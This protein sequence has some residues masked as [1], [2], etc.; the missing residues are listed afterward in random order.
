MIRKL[1]EMLKNL[2]RKVK[3][4]L[5]AIPFGMKAGDELLA[6]SSKDDNVGS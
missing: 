3:K 6:T 5:L 2:V 1:R 4:F